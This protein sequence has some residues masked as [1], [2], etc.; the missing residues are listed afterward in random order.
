MKKKRLI[1]IIAVIVFAIMLIPVPF[2]VEDGGS[3]LYLA[4]LYSV[5]KSHEL[6]WNTEV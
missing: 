6:R 2:G 5:E 3:E 1:I 4:I